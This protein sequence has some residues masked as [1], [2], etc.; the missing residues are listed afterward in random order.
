MNNAPEKIYACEIDHLCLWDVERA[1]KDDVE[2]VR[3]DLFYKLE[4]ELMDAQ[5]ELTQHG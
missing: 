2:Y 4:S 1:A 5:F 3:A